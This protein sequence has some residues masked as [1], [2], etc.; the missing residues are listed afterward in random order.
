MQYTFAEN[1]HL[2]LFL[3]D[4]CSI[5]SKQTSVMSMVTDEGLD[6]TM[7]LNDSLFMGPDIDPECSGIVN[8]ENVHFVSFVRVKGNYFI[9]M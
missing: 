8:G 5:D 2:F 9:C 1:N 3:D 4:G 7:G 6:M